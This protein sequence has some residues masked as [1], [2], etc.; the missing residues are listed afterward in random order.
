MASLK[1]YNLIQECV[2]QVMAYHIYTRLLSIQSGAALR[3]GVTWAC[4]V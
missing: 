1:I 3:R 4:K 2:L